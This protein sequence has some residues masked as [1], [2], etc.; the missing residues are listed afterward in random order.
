MNIVKKEIS[1]CCVLIVE[2]DF[3]GRA[4]LK[5]IFKKQGFTNIHEAEDGKEGLEKANE[6]LPDI[7]IMD[8]VMPEMDGVECCKRIRNS[9]DRRISNV[10]IVFQTALDGIADRARFFEAGATDYLTKPVDPHEITARV[11]VHLERSL[12]TRRLLEFNERISKEI[13]MAKETHKILIPDENNIKEIEENYNMRICS[14]YRPCSELGGD[15]WGVK[16]MSSDKLAF[17]NVDFSGH[18]VNAALNVFRLHAIMQSAIDTAYIPSA[19]LTHINAILSP[20]LPSGQFATMFYGIIDKKNNKLSYASAASPSAILFNKNKGSYELLEST[21]T[22]LGAIDRTSWQMK[23]VDFDSGDCLML[24]SDSLV[25]TGDKDGNF[26][27][28]EYWADLFCK[29]IKQGEGRKAFSGILDDFKE[30]CFDNITDDLTL[31]TYG[32][33]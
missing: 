28:V 3:L 32:C 2:D 5:E 13:N 18:G 31:T 7:I 1:D 4:V 15:F 19:Y 12:M 23:E 21:G 33:L 26:I 16:S 29:Y 25:E 22:L 24:Y 9:D 14:Y 6:L 11:V 30:K 8:V 10:P 20:L 27:E 17:Y